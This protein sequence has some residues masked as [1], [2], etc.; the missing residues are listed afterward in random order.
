VRLVIAIGVAVVVAAIGFVYL[1]V[2]D[3][4]ASNHPNGAIH[5]L[6]ETTRDR[7]VATRAADI[8]APDLTGAE[9]RVAG[10]KDFDAMCA[11]CHTPPGRARS[12]LA[13]GLNPPPPDLAETAERLSAAEIFWTIK[14]GIRMSG[15][16][17]WGPTHSDEELWPVVAFVQA[18]PEL[19]GHAYD[20]L[21]EQSSGSGHH[22]EADVD[23]ETAADEHHEHPHDHQH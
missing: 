22:H 14:N 13:Q 11:D 15:M 8:A 6:L 12:P 16:A 9:L 20:E 7:S 23:A 5:W 1:G 2:F 4:A 18:L 3:V 19:D 17:A 21:L 10:A